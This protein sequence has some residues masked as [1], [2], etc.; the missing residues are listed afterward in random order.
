M[1][2]PPTGPILAVS[3]IPGSCNPSTNLYTLSGTISLTNA[4]A[5]TLTI[6]DGSVSTAN[7]G[8]GGGP[9]PREPGDPLGAERRDRAELVDQH[10]RVLRRGAEYLGQVL[11]MRAEGG[12][13]REDRLLVSDIGVDVVE[14]RDA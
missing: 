12:E 13:A 14:D 10:K 9:R 2:T 1:T 4:V 3:V 7:A 5:S 6:T 8:F 11:Q